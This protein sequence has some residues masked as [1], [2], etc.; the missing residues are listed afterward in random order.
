MR[1]DASSPTAYRADV[2][3]ELSDI[4]ES[5][6]SLI[7]EVVLQVKEEIKYGM[8][9]YSL[10]DMELASLAA[11]KHYVSLYLDP[12]VVDQYRPQLKKLDTGKSCLRYRRT[13]QLDLQLLQKI[14]KNAVKRIEA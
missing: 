12:P 1:R 7:F 14:I 8:L 6:R 11:Q 3:G 4:L 13:D 5:I 9:H 10:N 2:S